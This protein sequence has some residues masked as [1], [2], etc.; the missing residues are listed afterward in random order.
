MNNRMNNHSF[1]FLSKRHC[2]VN[3]N[4]KKMN[5][6]NP[7]LKNIVEKTNKKVLIPKDTL[8]TNI[9]RTDAKGA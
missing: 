7:W 8:H 1:S 2:L 9:F 3:F 4:V 6:P 5:Y